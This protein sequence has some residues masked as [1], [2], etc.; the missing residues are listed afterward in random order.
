[1]K[2]E[3][4]SDPVS[5]VLL[6]REPHRYDKDELRLAA[7][8]AWDRLF[9]KA[10]GAGNFVIQSGHL[11]LMKAGS[12]LLGFPNA[13]QPYSDDPRSASRKL[14]RRQRS[15][16][17]EHRAWAAVDYMKGSADSE[18]KHRVLARIAAE[19]LTAFAWAYSFPQK[20]RFFRTMPPFMTPCEDSPQ[21][22]TAKE[23]PRIS[24]FVD[25]IERLDSP[26]DAQLA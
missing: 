25:I 10:A 5:I 17:M 12:H 3:D 21:I 23:P 6:L 15:T 22:G 26:P 4:S 24:N 14:P 7:E 8:R 9:E 11:T 2:P 13:P 20:A 18:L 16:W 1:M 19:M